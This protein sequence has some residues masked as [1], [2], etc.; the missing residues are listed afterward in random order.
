MPTPR[1]ATTSFVPPYPPSWFDHFTAWVDRLPGPAWAFYLILGVLVAVVET[2]VQWKEHAYPFGTFEAVH[3]FTAVIFVY[4]IGLMHYL[5]KS[6]AYALESFRPLLSSTSSEV[7]QTTEDQSAY[8][9]LSYELTTLPAGPA[10]VATIVGS[11]LALGDFAIRIAIGDTPPYLAGTAGT[12]LSTATF[13]TAFVAGNGVMV[14]LLYHTIHQLTRVGRIYAK[15]ARISVYRLK[16]LYA[17]SLPGA[18]TAIG[19]MLF[20]YAFL[21]TTTPSLQSAGVVTIVISLTFAAI[22]GVTF[23]LPLAGAHRRLV[24]EKDSRLADISARFDATTSRLHRQL[25]QNRLLQMD[26]LNKALSSLEIEHAVIKRVPTWPWEPGALRGLLATLLL[27]IAVWLI[28]LLIGRAL[29]A[30]P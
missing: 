7:R 5:D 1:T 14:L 26:S 20:I 29:G 22:A 12:T 13:M 8:G 19:I 21:S 15:H 27:P 28:Q 4:L 30:P 17:L 9:L 2:G 3:V 24:E 23:A 11:A 10:L 16:P 6:A 25:D 18:F